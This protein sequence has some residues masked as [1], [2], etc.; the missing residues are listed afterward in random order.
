MFLIVLLIIT[1]IGA[2]T[3]FFAATIGIS[4]KMIL[5]KV[6]AYSTCSQ[7][8][9]MIFACGLSNYSCKFISFN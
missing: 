9:Y 6:I 2:L 4:Y 3:A 8:G 5:K 1:F 7:L